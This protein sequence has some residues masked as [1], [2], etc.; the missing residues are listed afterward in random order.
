MGNPAKY[1]DPIIVVG[2]KKVTR[3]GVGIRHGCGKIKFN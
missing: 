2:G 3:L 1:F